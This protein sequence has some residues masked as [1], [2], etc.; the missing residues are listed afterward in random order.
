MRESKKDIYAEFSSEKYVSFM[1]DFYIFLKKYGIL[2]EIERL[3]KV[4]YP[5][6]CRSNL[7][8]INKKIVRIL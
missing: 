2:M 7:Q 5:I 6:Q 4:F 1:F 8:P 3:Q